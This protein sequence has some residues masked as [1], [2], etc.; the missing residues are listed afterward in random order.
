MQRFEGALAS[1]GCLPLIRMMQASNP[2]QAQNSWRISLPRF[3][4]T[5]G[6]RIFVQ[7]VKDAIFVEV[8]EVLSDKP[9]HVGL[10]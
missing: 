2:R 6:R 7:G 9:P 1:G 8:V 10:T 5:V 4:N 3:E